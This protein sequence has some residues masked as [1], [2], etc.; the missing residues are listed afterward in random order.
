METLVSTAEKEAPGLQGYIPEMIVTVPAEIRGDLE[1]IAVR[2]EL[3]A[4]AGRKSHD[5]GPLYKSIAETH[6]IRFADASGAEV[7]DDCEHLTE[8]GHKQ[9]AELLHKVITARP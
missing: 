9:L 5:I 8:E 1:K 4:A 6:G 2:F 7:S 3:T